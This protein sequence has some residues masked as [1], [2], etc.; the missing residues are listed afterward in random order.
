MSNWTLVRC[1]KP[2]SYLLNGEAATAQSPHKKTVKLP[3]TQYEF[4]LF[5]VDIFFAIKLLIYSRD[6]VAF[7]HVLMCTD[8]NLL[9]LYQI[10]FWF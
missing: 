5:S 3:E 9:D 8:T 4:H 7:S 2:K 1:I 10:Q 6:A